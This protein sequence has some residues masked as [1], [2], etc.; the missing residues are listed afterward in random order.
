[1][2]QINVLAFGSENF[3]TSLTEL[4]DHLNFK[5]TTVDKNI[6]SKLFE[7]YDIL[8]CHEDFLKDDLST[9]LLKNSEK[10]KVLALRSNQTKFDFF[11]E[12]I[13]LPT[14]IEN[15]NLIIENSIIKKKGKDK[16]TIKS[17]DKTKKTK[18]KKKIRTLWIRKKKLN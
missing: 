4:E 6:N 7:N 15:I 1:M 12:T 16:S 3:N 17:K 8:F 18:T 11:T 5:L 9:E 2:H 13:F 10:I 14:K